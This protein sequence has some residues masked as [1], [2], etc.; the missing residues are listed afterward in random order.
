MPK[1]AK[2]EKKVYNKNQFTKTVDTQFRT[3][4]PQQEEIRRVSVREFFRIYEQI[5][6]NIP[7]N[8]EI[9]SHEYLIRRSS[10]LVDITPDIQPLLNEISELRTRLLEANTR[11]LELETQQALSVNI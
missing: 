5:F 11:V 8:G 7:I 9:D 4:I 10:E 1:L 3:F 6:F 2:I